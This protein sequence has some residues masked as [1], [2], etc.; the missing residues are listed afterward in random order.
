MY[1]KMD[2]LEELSKLPESKHVKKGR[3]GRRKKTGLPLDL[4]ERL[5]KLHIE[6]RPEPRPEG[7]VPNRPE[8]K[9]I[10]QKA[11]A[12]DKIGTKLSEQD[13]IMKRYT[14]LEDEI[15]HLIKG[16]KG[17]GRDD[18]GG[19]GGDDGDDNVVPVVKHR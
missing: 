12:F 1:N 4:D 14:K 8:L 9:V 7:T 2:L 18:D 3:V 5:L 13:R 16:K 15:V 10:T 19:D 6:N 17:A 11:A